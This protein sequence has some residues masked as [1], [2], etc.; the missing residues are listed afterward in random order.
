MPE[1][2]GVVNAVSSDGGG[3][4]INDSWL[5][6]SREGYEGTKPIRGQRITVKFN[7]RADGRPGGWITGIDILD[8]GAVQQRPAGGG[9]GRGLP[10]QDRRE[11]RRMSVL[12]AAAD[13]AGRLSMSQAEGEK[14]KSADVLRIAESWLKWVEQKPD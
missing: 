13:F 5:N 10:E 11:I 1:I 2:T 8:G 9:G 12:K 6:Y 3:F 4:K 7:E 14:I